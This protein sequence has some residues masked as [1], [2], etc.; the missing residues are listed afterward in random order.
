MPKR[1]EH[2]EPIPKTNRYG[3]EWSGRRNQG[4]CREKQD[5]SLFK[6]GVNSLTKNASNETKGKQ[7]ETIEFKKSMV[8]WDLYVDIPLNIAY[9]MG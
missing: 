6:K 9:V 7:D 3:M 8:G 5:A 1:G 4:D 2:R